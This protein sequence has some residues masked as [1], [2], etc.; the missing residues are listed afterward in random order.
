MKDGE[1]IKYCGNWQTREAGR[2]I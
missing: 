2:A 1:D